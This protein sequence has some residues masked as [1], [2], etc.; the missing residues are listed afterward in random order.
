MFYRPL[1]SFNSA[2]K[3]S[4]LRFLN[5]FQLNSI[6]RQPL[7]H[8]R[9]VIA[10]VRL[11]RAQHMHPRKV[12]SRERAVVDDLRDVCPRIRQHPRQMR[13]PARPV[14]QQHIK[15]PDASVR[16]QPALDR[17]APRRTAGDDRGVRPQQAGGPVAVA[18]RDDDDDMVGGG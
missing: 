16:R 9:D 6:L 7:P 15:A 11:H 18:L 5:R 13:Q 2:S 12:R 4:F 3:K 10:V 14:A 1:N 8:R 17:L